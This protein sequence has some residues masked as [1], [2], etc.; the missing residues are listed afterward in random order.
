MPLPDA[1][2]VRP[3]VTSRG[4]ERWRYEAFAAVPRGSSFLCRNETLGSAMGASRS[5]RRI[6]REFQIGQAHIADHDLIRADGCRR[7]KPH[8]PT[9]S[10]KIVLVHTVTADAE[11]PH[12][13]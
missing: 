11:S 1:L 3:L 10:D 8:G 6:A 7:F 12:Q 9:I 2:R 13:L 5:I 4:V